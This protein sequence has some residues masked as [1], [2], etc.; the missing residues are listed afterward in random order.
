MSLKSKLWNASRIV[1]VH[2]YPQLQNF[3]FEKASAAI[4]DSVNL[5]FHRY[6]KDEMD[7]KSR[8]TK[9]HRFLYNFFL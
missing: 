6:P 4:V 5:I 1:Q 8:N 2:P 7:T 9:N 3:F